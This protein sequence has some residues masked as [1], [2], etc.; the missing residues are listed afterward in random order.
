[1]RKIVLLC[2]LAAAITA[3][4]AVISPEAALRRVSADTRVQTMS[5]SAVVPRLVYTQQAG[6]EPAAYIFDRGNGVGY[7]IVSADDEVTPLLGYSDTGSVDTS[8]MPDGLRYWLEYYAAE[9]ESVRTAGSSAGVTTFASS[10]SRKAIAPMISTSWDQSEPFNNK[11]PQVGSTR[12]VTGCVATAMAQVMKY[13]NWPEKGTGSNSYSWNGTTLSLDFSTVTF[14]WGNMLDVY[15]STATEAQ[16]DAV[17]T[18]MYACGISVDMNYGTGASGAVSEKCGLAL[19]DNFNYDAS[20]RTLYRDYY[21]L[22]EWEEVVY[23]S[24]AEGCPVLYGGQSNSGGHEFVCDGYSSDG[25][26]H[27]NW[28]WGGMSDCYFK[29]TALN[30]GAQGIGGA[31]SGAGYNFGQDIVVGIKPFAGQSEL[32]PMLGNK[33]D[34]SVAETSVQL[35]ERITVVAQAGNTGSV[36]VTFKYGVGFTDAAGQTVYAPWMYTNTLSLDPGYFYNSPQTY[37]VVIPTGLASGEYTVKPAFI[38]D[39]KWSDMPTV[40]GKNGSVRMTVANGSATF[41]APVEVTLPEVTGYSFS[42]AVYVGLPYEVKGTVENNGTLEYY[43]AV[44]GMLIA[45]S[46]NTLLPRMQLD[47]MPG[48]S[49][50]L[51]Y[52]GTMPTDVAAGDYQFAFVVR[53]DEGYTPVSAVTD[54]TVN[55]APASPE[56]TLGAVSFESGSNRVPRNDLGVKTSLTC[57]SGAYYGTLDMVVFR[58]IDSMSWRSVAEFPSEMLYLESGDTKDVVY[59]SD[60]SDGTV[61]EAYLL[62]FYYDYGSARFSTQELIVLDAD[63]NGVGDVT[64]SSE[65]VAVELYNLNGQRVSDRPAPGHY[66]MVKRMPDGTVSSEHMI[67][68]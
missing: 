7:M 43:D 63:T 53:T 11:C 38:S 33:C 58:K 54:L 18:L 57:S 28:G 61:G 32:N 31:G 34:F 65:P 8:D 22:D 50:E 59:H 2:C 60:F 55:A 4:A 40:V 9:I 39:D 14:D 49:A 64:V 45:S 27:F 15:G 5:T 24:L 42:S 10:A 12:T 62:M 48:E 36:A 1:M 13:H 66:I 17:A 37:Y 16:N 67:I 21:P 23:N 41:A 35:G 6:M 68:K 29:L 3:G 44:Y 26:F 51:I 56:L 52:S 30:P 19:V 20:L 47:L 46:G 25:Y